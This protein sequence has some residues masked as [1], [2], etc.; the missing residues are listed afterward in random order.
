MGMVKKIAYAKVNLG[1]D[2]I[3]KRS[4]G[5][6]DVKMIMQNVDIYD[7]LYFESTS[8][9][10]VHL[11][12]EGGR[13]KGSG[14]LPVN[15]D[16]LVCK[17]VR[18]LQEEY[19]IHEGVQIRLVKNIPIAAGMAGGSS[20]AA[21][22]FHGM[23]EL[24]DLKLGLKEMCALGVRIGA[25]VPYCIMGK[26]ALAEGIGEILTPVAKPP[27]CF[28]LI[29][30]PDCEVSTKYVYENL[31]LGEAKE[32]VDIDG[33]IHAMERSDLKG[34]TEKMGNILEGVTIAMHPVIDRIKKIMLEQG[35]LTA[36]M[37]GSGPTVFGIFSKE[38][39]KMAEQAVKVLREEQNVSDV[40]LTS[41]VR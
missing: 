14:S 18:L 12:L 23:N 7:E 34:M 5:Y 19:S 27:E 38:E 13:S 21:A 29:A 1:L 20:D 26:T 11:F 24:F 31:K 15:E 9:K 41:F 30:K 2:V 10:G 33:L 25:D 39:Q 40:Y 36:L 3:R 4:D 32:T 37:S 6:H 28:V 8:K 17:A 22:V 16:N 35:A